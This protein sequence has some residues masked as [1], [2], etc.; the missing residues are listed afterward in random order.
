MT[1]LTDTQV[2]TASGGLVE[3][4]YAE[5][6]ANL[7]ITATTGAGMDNISPELTVV[8]D[9]SPIMVEFFCA[10]AR[11]TVSGSGT[12]DALWFALKVD[13]SVEEERLGVVGNVASG[14]GSL[15]PIKLSHRMTPSAG[16]HTFRVGGW[17]S[18]AAR[19]GYIGGGSPYPPAWIRVSKIVEATQW[20]A[21]TTGTI[22]CTSSTRPAS[23][24]EGQVIY[25]TDT[26]LSLIYDG[27][28]WV[29]PSVTHKPPSAQI[30]HPGNFTTN[31]GIGITV[32]G[33][34]TVSWDTDSMT[35]TADRLTINTPG[36][37]SAHA[38]ILTP[39]GNS[40][41]YRMGIRITQYN[42]GGSQVQDLSHAG[43]Y[44][45]IGWGKDRTVA[46]VFKCSTSDYFTMRIDVDS[47]TNNTGMAFPSALLQATFIGAA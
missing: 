3:L 44:I 6:D 1:S 29:S 40:T 30:T 34:S 15:T 31:E 28:A 25:E 4:G 37:Y 35:T 11:A 45:T 9:G 13:G 16:S 21:V 41:D 12:T 38:R 27:S 5:N 23:P 14:Y 8:C 26:G 17:V 43:S 47:S 22:I 10:G 32:T 7:S 18:N 20:P 42:S 19:S 46:G 24:F 36:L 33:I 39:A 2:V